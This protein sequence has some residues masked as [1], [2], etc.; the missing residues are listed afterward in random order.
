MNNQGYPPQNQNNGYPAWYAPPPV[1]QPPSK[2]RRSGSASPAGPAGPAD[3][4]FTNGRFSNGGPADGGFTNNR[5]TNGGPA[6]GGFTNNRYTNGGPAGPADGGYT[7][8]GFASSGP[9]N[10]GPADSGF[11]NGRFSNGGGNQRGTGGRK[12]PSLK[13]Q[14]I[15]V[16]LV[17]IVLGGVGVGGYFWKVQSDI[18]PYR[19]VFLPNITVDGIDLS[20]M[21]W[22][23]GSAAVWAQA[24]EKSNSWYVRLKNVSGEY[25][26]ITA[27]MLGISFD[28]TAALE[29]AWAIGHETN[30]QSRKDIFQLKDELLGAQQSAYEFYSA[31]QSADTTPIDNILSTLQ[32]VAYKSA[33]DAQL[34]S[35]NPDDSTNPFTF[36]QEVYGQRLDTT[37][38]K[39]QI[40]DMVHNLQSGEVMLETTLINPSV[41]VADLEKTVELRYR[42]ITPISSASTE[43]R[44]EN[45]RLAFSRINGMTLQD[46]KKFSFNSAV[47]KRSMENGFYSAIEYA[48]GEEVIGWGGGVCQASTTVYLA[49]VQ[50]GLKITNREPHS[51]PVSYTD[52]GMDATVS[53][54]RGHEIDFTFTNNSGGTIYMAAH[55]IQSSTSKRTYLCE[56]RI[57]GLSL[58]NTSYALQAQTVETIPKPEE[59]YLKEDATG[60]H[61]TYQDETKLYSKGR[62][63]YVVES[64]LVTVVDGQET[65]RVSLGKD[66]Y[67]AKPDRYYVGVTPRY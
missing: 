3:S 35:F 45:I 57:Y 44:T 18:R 11:T 8:N 2:R 32:T 23:D 38:A 1:Q 55:V 31:E 61:V 42:A 66:K 12:K 30:A 43:S 25:K 28:P 62:E 20:G 29:Q 47:G 14:L 37:A 59:P 9:A 4:G 19:S 58:G 67:D 7:Y 27:S 33:Q 54:T 39:E 46:G 40:L 63:G 24:N 49:A 10:G 65:G 5:Y 51:N 56:V 52:M 53:D 50:S 60:E 22:A 36:Q 64:F 41:T 16:L 26:D 21:S 13:W 6:D 17:L 34:I 48:Y 15:K